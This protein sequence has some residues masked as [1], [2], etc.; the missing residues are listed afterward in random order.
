MRAMAK[1]GWLQRQ[2]PQAM[3][4]PVEP[5]LCQGPGRSDCCRGARSVRPVFRHASRITSEPGASGPGP[6]TGRG[7]SLSLGDWALLLPVLSGCVC[8]LETLPNPAS[9]GDPVSAW[10]CWAWRDVRL[11]W[12]LGRIRAIMAPF[13]PT[14]PTLAHSLVLSSCNIHTYDA[15]HPSRP[16]Q[17]TPTAAGCSL[18]T[19]TYHSGMT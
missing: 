15:L 4:S 16:Q 5:P 1:Q 17:T 9:A 10:A 11:H 6:P 7:V 3:R 13:R 18:P 8:Y 19:V 2:H 14:L 12:R